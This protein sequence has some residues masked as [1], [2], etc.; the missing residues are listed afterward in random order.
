MPA[1]VFEK[2]LA[3][4]VKLAERKMMNTFHCKTADCTGWCIYEDDVNIFKCPVCT[5][6]NCI[7]CAAIHEGMDCKQYQRQ[8]AI[9][10]ETD[11]NAKSSR[12]MLEVFTHKQLYRM[13]G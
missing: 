2:Y 6:K 7:T 5:K 1:D 12:L 9:D 13:N 8:L 11:E 3:R 4:S 10:S